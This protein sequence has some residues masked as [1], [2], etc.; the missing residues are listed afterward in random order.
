MLTELEVNALCENVESQNLEHTESLSKFDKFGEAICAFSNDL[1]KSNKAGYLLIGINSQGKRI[2][3]KITDQLLQ[4]LAAFRTDGNIL[5]CPQLSVSK[6]VFPDGEVAVVEVFPSNMPPVRYKGKVCV[7]VGPRKGVATEAEETTLTEKRVSKAKTFDMW[8]CEEAD[9]DA[10]SEPLFR[11]FRAQAVSAEV[12]A[13]NHRSIQ[14][15]MASL[16][17]FDAKLICPTNAG[18]LCFGLNVR[19]FFPGA[20]IQYLRIDGKNLEDPVVDQLEISGTLE[21]QVKTCLE[22][23]NAINI[24][25]MKM[26]ENLRE[27]Q[28][29]MWPPVAI[30]EILLNALLHRDYNSNTPIRFY[31]FLDRIEI[32]NA[33]ALYGELNATNFREQQSYRNPV[34]AEYLKTIGLVNKFGYGIAN[35]E[36]E[37]KSNGNEPLKLGPIDGGFLAVVYAKLSE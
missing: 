34:L 5:P 18:V 7:R 33:G 36:R 26:N 32:Q 15:Q 13:E 19:Y 1:I 22:K 14:H 35:A 10:L 28:I 20:Y 4:Q 23:F 12:I 17:Y 11:D 21:S 6:F 16:R 2:G 27:K 24:F 3:S 8:R 37:L 30:R 9:L 29:P 25:K 31:V